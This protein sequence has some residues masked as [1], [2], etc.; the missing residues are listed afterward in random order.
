MPYSLPVYLCS[1]YNF[2]EIYLYFNNFGLTF[3]PPCYTSSDQ[4][5]SIDLWPIFFLHFQHVGHIKMGTSVVWRKVMHPIA[6]QDFRKQS[7]TSK[8]I[9]TFPLQS[10]GTVL[11]RHLKVKATLKL[12]FSLN[13]SPILLP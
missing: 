6:D 8:Q 7:G 1:C 4:R 5:C 2:A 11:L 3:T 12:R 13:L 10:P 9:L